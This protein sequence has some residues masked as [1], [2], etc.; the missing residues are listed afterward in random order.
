[1]K[2]A[3]FTSSVGDTDLALGTVKSLE[4]KGHEIILISLTK[5][6]QQRMENF[7]SSAVVQKITI[8][9][10]LK[11][12]PESLPVE[13]R[14]SEYQVKQV[15]DFT[16]SQKINHAF[17]GVP[18]TN[19]NE[20]P[21]QIA[22]SLEDIS[23]LM[24][25][26][27]MFKPE[28]HTIWTHLPKL[29]GKPHLQWAL[30]LKEA[31]ADFGAGEGL[32]IIG[33][34]SIDNAYVPKPPATKTP[35]T[36]K[37]ALQI[38]KEQSLAFI[39]STTQP[40]ATDATFLDYVLAELPNHPTIQIR[41]G[42]HPGIEDLDAYLA[43]ILS[44]AQK[45]TDTK[46]FKIIF[47]DKLVS[48]IKKPEL[49]IEH[50]EFR[51]LFLRVNIN[52]AEASSVADKVA[53][54]V[55]GALLNQAA[56]EGK[57]VYS[58]KGKPYLPH[59]YFSNSIAAFFTSSNQPI[60]AKKDLGLSEKSA[61]DQ[62]AELILKTLSE[63]LTAYKQ[64]SLKP[65]AADKSKCADA[66]DSHP[67]PMTNLENIPFSRTMIMLQKHGAIGQVIIDS[68]T[69]LKQGRESY[70]NPYWMN[71]G[72]K[73][74]RITQAVEALQDTDTLSSIMKDERSALYLALNMQRITPITLFGRL[75]INQS[76]TLLM[77]RDEMDKKESEPLSLS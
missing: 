20:I 67:Q 24:A 19:N 3:F 73:L 77:V 69:R 65:D 51:S 16:R 56:L 6:A 12:T 75:S 14:C 7:Q 42:I 48:R 70:W 4:N 74:E 43:H 52:G 49:T 13:I 61:P 39:S 66:E 45:N 71:S 46:Q 30:P 44:I 60:R 31:V 17:F 72:V 2:I 41:W 8:A 76:K 55:P 47:E 38:T 54:A 26:E 27:F 57:P 64:V 59:Q 18:S 50:P 23:V 33:H 32:N 10:I 15:V 37:A 68:M 1:M 53:Q 40:V 35:E 9:E 5:T 28:G 34:M 29:K 63:Q 22:E 21:F 58:H 25:Y 62:C 36:I 11:L